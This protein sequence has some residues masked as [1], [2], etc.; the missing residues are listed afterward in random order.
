M[1]LPVPIQPQNDDLSVYINR[2]D[3]VCQILDR[4]YGFLKPVLP[5]FLPFLL[6][7]RMCLLIWR[8]IIPVASSMGIFAISGVFIGFLLI[9]QPPWLPG[10]LKIQVGT[11]IGVSIA[12]VMVAYFI[13]R[14][15]SDVKGFS[16]TGLSLK[17]AHEKLTTQ[18]FIGLPHEANLL[19]QK[20]Q[21]VI[22]H[23]LSVYFLK[24]TL[25]ETSF[26]LLLDCPTKAS[27]Y[28]LFFPWIKEYQ[29][30]KEEL[31][32]KHW[33][34]L[35]P[36]LQSL[37]SLITSLDQGKTPR[38]RSVLGV[39]WC[40]EACLVQLLPSSEKFAFA[41]VTDHELYIRGPVLWMEWIHSKLKEGKVS[42]VK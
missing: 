31:A 8:N 35:L 38:K 17:E 15:Y 3:E 14:R 22:A 7:A 24:D 21:A 41:A 2:L 23:P 28:Y 11:V 32:C 12:L 36:R 40:L 19:I 16:V 13:S 25:Q 29:A 9:Y 1:S 18:G 20:L 30:F 6:I 33:K 5:W 42:L 39:F 27:Q 10:S 4:L 26:G 34:G 37:W